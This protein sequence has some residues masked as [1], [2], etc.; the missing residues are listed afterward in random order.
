M[1]LVKIAFIYDGA[2]PWNKGGVEKRLYEIGRRLAERGHE[3]HWYCVGW[4]LP[5]EEKRDIEFDGIEYH[6]VCR[7]LQLYVD[8]RRSIKAAIK[9][10]LSLIWPFSRERFDIIDCQNFPYFSCFSAKFWSSLKSTPLVITWHEYWGDYWY[11]YLGRKGVFGKIIEDIV[12]RQTKYNVAVSEKIAKKLE[13]KG[14]KTRV[15]PNGIDIKRIESIKP[16]TIKSDAIFV[17]RLIKHKNVDILIKS[18]DILK[19][20]N[21]SIKCL[22][23][24]DGPESPKLKR[25]T[26]E[27]NLED[28]IKFL[29]FIENYEKMI[30][31]MKS[32]NVLVLP[33]TREGFG[34]VALEANAAGLPV[35]T[36]EHPNNVTADLI[37]KYGGGYVCALSSNE[38]A[39]R[40]KET[41]QEDKTIENF[42]KNYDWDKIVDEVESFYEGCL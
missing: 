37:K 16:S 41:I 36:I 9:F 24:G 26:K 35:I 7:P 32:S 27:L 3:V 19:E 18:I 40:I 11:E 10:S 8:G 28:N 42:S 5:Q 15:I 4:W 20:E 12:T 23:I 34:I 13:E 29:H 22:I 33:S 17:G 31:Y 30:G 2:Y 6:G 21:P 25:L 39:R 38:I 1:I 14:I